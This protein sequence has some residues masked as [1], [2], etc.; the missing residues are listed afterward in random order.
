MLG[1]APA[2]AAD[3]VLALQLAPSTTAASQLQP[4]KAALADARRR[5]TPVRSPL[6]TLLWHGSGMALVMFALHGA[7]QNTKKNVLLSNEQP[8]RL[9][10]VKHT[11]RTY[12]HV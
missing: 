10:C 11:H 4:V 12:T 8:W 9:A 6:Y 1:E 5:G 3:L 2:A 7:T